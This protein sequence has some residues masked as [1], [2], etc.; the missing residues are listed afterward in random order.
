MSPVVIVV[1]L[2]PQ[3]LCNRSNA[4]KLGAQ[5][6]RLCAFAQEVYCISSAIILTGAL[7]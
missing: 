3:A 5:A 4:H 6:R 7:P 1:D 2:S